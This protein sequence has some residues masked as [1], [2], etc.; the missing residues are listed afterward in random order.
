MFLTDDI[1]SR[2]ARDGACR[3]AIV[4][5]RSA[6]REIVEVPSE[7]ALWLVGWKRVSREIVAELAESKI[8]AVRDAASRRLQAMDR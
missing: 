7:W 1:L 8:E 4:W 3:E 5:A 2:A 6:P